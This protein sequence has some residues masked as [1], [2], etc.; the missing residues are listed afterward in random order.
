MNEGIHAQV[1]GPHGLLWSASGRT[2]V[3]RWV[4]R[5]VQM[6]AGDTRRYGTT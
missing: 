5:F 2:S 4:S 6:R 1:P 3:C